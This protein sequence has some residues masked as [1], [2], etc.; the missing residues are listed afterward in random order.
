M[1]NT[2]DTTKHGKEQRPQSFSS[3]SLFQ[4][5]KFAYRCKY[6]DKIAEP[7]SLHLEYGK[8][9]HECIEKGITKN[10][11]IPALDYAHKYGLEGKKRK[12]GSSIPL[13]V[14][15]GQVFFEERETRFGLSFSEN[16]NEWHIVDFDNKEA[17]YRGIIDFARIYINKDKIQND[18][19]QSIEKIEIID[20]KTGNSNANP[21]QIKTY[22][23]YYCLAT[24][25]ENIEAKY[26]YL[27]RQHETF[28]RFT[29]QDFQE[30][31]AWIIESAKQIQEAQKYPPTACWKCRF[32]GYKELCAGEISK[33]SNSSKKDINQPN[34]DVSGLKSLGFLD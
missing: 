9:V 7:T 13:W 25:C 6:I 34:F 30:I 24:G 18:I 11:G 16:S 12:T 27:S 5:C 1:N 26:V 4:T 14:Y 21:R 15:K 2:A 3:I 17:I 10:T 29:R 8:L 22:A 19:F 33:K 31:G 32:C 28:Y 20:W 23:F